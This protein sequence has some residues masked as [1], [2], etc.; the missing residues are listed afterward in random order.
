[1]NK[2]RELALHLVELPPNRDACIAA[3]STISALMDV[4]EAGGMVQPRPAPVM[5]LEPLRSLRDWHLRLSTTQMSLES[6]KW[7]RGVVD[8]L[9]AYFPKDDQL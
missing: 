7:H 3:A 2:T 4:I 1:M 9:N 6:R 8:S 5:D